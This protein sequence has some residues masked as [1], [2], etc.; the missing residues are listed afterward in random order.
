MA[1]LGASPKLDRYAFK[2]MRML[3][4]SGFAAI[5][6][7]PAFAEILGQSCFASIAEVPQPIDTI[8]MYLG[9]QRSDPLIEKII[10]AKPKRIIFNPGAENDRL[11]KRAASCGIETV[12][13]CTLIMLQ[14]GS[15]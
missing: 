2:A 3:L 5:P 7:N 15:F 14:A 9:S 6:V 11:E 8:T 12:H 1:V 10:S 4:Q 13:D